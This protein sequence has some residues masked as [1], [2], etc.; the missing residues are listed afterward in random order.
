M[1]GAGERIANS[2]EVRSYMDA[3]TAATTD[4][5]RIR[6]QIAQTN[7]MIDSA[8]VLKAN[9]EAEFAQHNAQY[10]ATLQ[11]LID[12]GSS[13][14]SIVGNQL[15]SDCAHAA[16]TI[17]QQIVT[18]S[19]QIAYLSASIPKF[20]DAIAAKQAEIEGILGQQIDAVQA[21]MNG[22]EPRAY[23]P[24]ARPMPPKV[25]QPFTKNPPSGVMHPRR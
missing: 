19:N 1:A 23:Q 24:A 22:E 3:I 2:P 6:L 7:A 12:L 21:I 11:G 15:A 4:I 20:D 16:N 10:A 8:Q 13:A 18:V 17:Q 9:F 25:A 5:D 14:A